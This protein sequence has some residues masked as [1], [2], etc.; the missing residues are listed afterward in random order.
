[1]ATSLTELATPGGTPQSKTTT[2]NKDV[3][4]IPYVTTTTNPTAPKVLQ[5]TPRTHQR[6][7]RNNTPGATSPIEI[8]LP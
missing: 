2:D 6:I 8:P 3:N 7:T 1:M 5:D 4:V